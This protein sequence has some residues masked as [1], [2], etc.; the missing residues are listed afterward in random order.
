MGNVTRTETKDASLSILRLQR[1]AFDELGRT[2][3]DIGASNQTTVHGYDNNS[4]LTATT[5][6]LSHP[7]GRT[8]DALDRLTRITDPLTGQ[9][10]YTYDNRDN[11]TSVSDQRGLATS[12]VY[13][14]FGNLI[15]EANPD[16]GTTV[17]QVD[18]VFRSHRRIPKSA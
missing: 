3:R 10:N 11:L 5:D 18:L 6:P 9:I 12:Y 17:Y 14:G 8:F 7:W 15:Q 2:L 16:A 1:A 13:D 4:N